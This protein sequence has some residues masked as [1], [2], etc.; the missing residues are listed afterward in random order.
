[1]SRVAPEIIKNGDDMGCWGL[2]LFWGK[3]LYSKRSVINRK[4]KLSVHFFERYK[5]L[6]PDNNQTFLFNLTLNK[7]CNISY[8]L[9]FFRQKKNAA[10]AAFISFSTSDTIKSKDAIYC[11][12]FCY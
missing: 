11:S 8:H 6:S 3:T 7:K 2:S 12:N 1:M 5:L 9:C 10:K 4:T